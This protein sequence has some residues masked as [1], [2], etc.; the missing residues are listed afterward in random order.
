MEK[1]LSPVAFAF[2]VGVALLTLLGVAVLLPH[3]RYYRYQGHDS[4]TTRKA[5]WIYER[6]HFDPAPIDVALIGTS[7]TAG[8]LSAL[9]IERDYCRTTG[10]RIHVANLGVP[11]MG[12]NMHYAIA[13]EAGRAKAP[14]LF[15]IELNEIEARRPHDGFILVADAADV[16]RAP[17]A[18]NANYAADLIRLPGRQINLFFETI[19]ERP[20]VRAQFD[21]AEYEGYFDRTNAIELLDG[22]EIDKRVE[23]PRAE[24]DDLYAQRLAAEAPISAFP[25]PLRPFEYRY[26][27]K[28]LSAIEEVARATGA[29][30]GYA[31]L[32]AYRSPV[33]PPALLEQLDIESVNIDLGGP[34]AGDASLWFDATHWNARGAAIASARMAASL[35]KAYPYLGRRESCDGE[36]Q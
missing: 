1:S 32:P 35:A 17:A 36:L 3:D 12:R 33:M 30:I 11:E 23:K 7:R 4:G 18:I 31:F 16:L 29:E 8:G 27:R 24:L 9:T 22:R 21:P 26:A 2:A 34:S 25:T 13:K 6:L 28:Y 14:K 5:D 10:R 19:A 15:I 20:R